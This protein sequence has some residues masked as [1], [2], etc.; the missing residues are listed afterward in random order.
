M[1]CWGYQ[2]A[3]VHPAPLTSVVQTKQE[4]PVK[5]GQYAKFATSA[6]SELSKP[7]KAAPAIGYGRVSDGENQYG[8]LK[9]ADLSIV[10]GGGTCGSFG[11]FNDAYMV[12]AGYAD[13]HDGICQGDSGG[14]LVVDGVVVG[15]ASWVKIGCG[16][17]GA[18]GRL[19]NEMGDW[20]KTQLPDVDP[21]PRARRSRRPSRSRPPV[22]PSTPRPPRT[23]TARSPRTPGSSVTA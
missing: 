21:G 11:T 3:G 23:R 17:Y 22:A 7:G 9:K 10:A 16:S 14:P 2:N 1:R 4:I 13:G 18:W 6:D 15:V 5:D 8:H 12:C 19:T 20:V